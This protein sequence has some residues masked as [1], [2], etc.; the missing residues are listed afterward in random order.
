MA[1][2]VMVFNRIEKKYLLNHCQYLRLLETMEQYMTL[3]QYG[4]HTICNIYY[5]TWEDQL[6]RNNFQK[7]I[8]KEKLRL[9]S[10]G[11]PDQNTPVFLEIKKK[12]QGIVYK[13]RICFPLKELDVVLQNKKIAQ[14]QIEKEIAYFIDFYKPLPRMY[15]A[16]DR[17]AFYGNQDQNLRITIDENIRS[18]TNQ[19]DLTLGDQGELLFK[20]PTYLVE[21]KTVHA[22]PF[23]LVN[24][25]NQAEIY[26]ASF[27]KYNNVYKK[28]FNER[29]MKYV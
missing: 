16:Y 20:E 28:Q 19:L 9:R 18:R 11:I 26:P 14:T 10:Y 13:R 24:V 21:I 17:R 4:K 8:Y 23:W 7:P 3:D 12:Y 27:S 6:V 5:D 15:L 1:E 2:N 25:L 22:Y 29:M